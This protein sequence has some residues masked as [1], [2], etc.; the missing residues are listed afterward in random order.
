VAPESENKQGSYSIILSDHD[1]RGNFSR[2][3]T[4]LPKKM[5]YQ[6]STEEIR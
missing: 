1:D 5:A 3:W 4:P 2:V 6:N